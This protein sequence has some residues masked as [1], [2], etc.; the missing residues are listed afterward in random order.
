MET[1][2]ACVGACGVGSAQMPSGARFGTA[3][4]P[5]IAPPVIAMAVLRRSTTP[6]LGGDL[7]TPG[8]CG[9]GGGLDAAAH[10]APKY[11]FAVSL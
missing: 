8:G 9:D 6:D 2:A 3:L 4:G 10:A 7:P 11:D 1:S 5:T